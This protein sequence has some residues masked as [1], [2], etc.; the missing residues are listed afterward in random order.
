M[1]QKILYEGMK[2]VFAPNGTYIPGKMFKLEKKSIRSV[3]GDGCFA[4][5]EELCLSRD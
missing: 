1:E 2:T 3:E 4:L 5:K